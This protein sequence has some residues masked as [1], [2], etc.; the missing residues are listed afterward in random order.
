MTEEQPANTGQPAPADMDVATTRLDGHKV[1]LDVTLGQA[2]VARAYGQ[3]YRQLA[4]RVSVPGFRR[5]HVP[6]PVLERHVGREAFREEALELILSEAYDRALDSADVD[7]IDRPEVNVVKFEEDEPFVF[8]ATVEVKPEV[9]LPKYAGLDLSVPPKAVTESDVEAQLNAIRERQAQLEPAEAE[10]TLTDGLFGVLD[11][12]GTV[13]GEA[14]AGG[15]AENALIQMGAGQLEPQIET[16]IRGARAGEDREAKVS[17]PADVPNQKLQGKE[18]SFRIRVKEIKRKTLPEL[19]DDLAKE[20]TGLD[21]PTLRERVTK[22]LEERANADA[23]D[24]LVRQVVERITAEAEVDV[25]EIMVK[26]RLERMTADTEE[27]LRGQNISLDQYLQIVGLEREQWEKDARSRAEHAVKKDLVL[28]AISKR[29]KIQAT[30]AEIEFEIA[31]AAATYQQKPDKMRTFFRG[32]SD[33]LESL[34]A[35]II[36]Q[37]TIQHLVRLNTAPVAADTEAAGEDRP[38]K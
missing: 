13:D 4:G 29:E 31:R 30:E 38:V 18:A 20:I 3:A 36:T 6:R 34:K 1:R 12:E 25:P 16:A 26:R 21:L 10:A 14:F 23:R 37:K 19:S 17:F 7:P 2:E 8:Q 32:S 5:G 9:K 11:Y 28:G 35:G 27:R 15:K 22:S 24:E 33:R